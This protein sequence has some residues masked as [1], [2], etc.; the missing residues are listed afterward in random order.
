MFEGD[1]LQQQ[2]KKPSSS[3]RRPCL[4]CCSVQL[5]PIEMST[6]FA[7]VVQFLV[8]SESPRTY[9]ASVNKDGRGVNETKTRQTQHGDADFAHA[10][11]E[12][13]QFVCKKRE[14][15]GGT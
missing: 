4:P 2:K 15:S 5:S 3:K 8:C 10:E 11:G 12:R 1:F 13:E 7:S 14:R 9:L 6:C